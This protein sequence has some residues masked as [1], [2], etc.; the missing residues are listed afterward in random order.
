MDLDLMIAECMHL[1][2]FIS[3]SSVHMKKGNTKL[4]MPSKNFVIQMMS[5]WYDNNVIFNGWKC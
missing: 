3:L 1:H 5:L 4:S 2:T